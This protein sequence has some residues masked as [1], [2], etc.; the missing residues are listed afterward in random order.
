MT[1]L[2]FLDAGNNYYSITISGNKILY[3]TFVIYGQPVRKRL[4][5][6]KLQYKNIIMQ[7]PDLIDTP[8]T[9][10]RIIAIKRLKEHI[11]KFT[12]EEELITYLRNDL[13]KH[14][15]RLKYINKKGFRT[16]VVK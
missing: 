7:N 10:A 2:V 15:H 16:Q 1:D 9:E 13:A 3:L 11:D 4:E 8:E 14:G 6:L 12:T 5:D